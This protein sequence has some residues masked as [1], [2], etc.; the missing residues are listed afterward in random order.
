[1][2]TT[3]ESGK[4]FVIVP[5]VRDEIGHDEPRP[6]P[7]DHESAPA[8]EHSYSLQYWLDLRR[9]EEPFNSIGAVLV[10]VE[11]TKP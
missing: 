11:D 8:N 2:E 3:K 7:N 6:S 1:M 9:D 10:E 4:K 5:V